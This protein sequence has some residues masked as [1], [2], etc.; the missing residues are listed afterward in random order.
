MRL[1]RDLDDDILELPSN[2]VSSVDT[3]LTALQ[4]YSQ[5]PCDSFAFADVK[6]IHTKHHISRKPLFPFSVE[7]EDFHYP[8]PLYTKDSDVA[9]Y[10]VARLPKYFKGGFHLGVDGNNETTD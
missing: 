10:L 3:Y 2:F 7:A 9:R 1:V 4:K 5:N 8:F 6:R